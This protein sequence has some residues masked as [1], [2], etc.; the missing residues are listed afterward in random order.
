MC[1]NLFAHHCIC[2]FHYSKILIPK[3]KNV[4]ITC[5]DCFIEKKNPEQINCDILNLH[6]INHK[7][8]IIIYY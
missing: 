7:I 3:Q 8:F 2:D 5:Q 1:P 6:I 4:K